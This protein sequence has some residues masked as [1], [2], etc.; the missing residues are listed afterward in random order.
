MT[1]IIDLS[2][3]ADHPLMNH[4]ELGPIIYVKLGSFRPVRRESQAAGD[5]S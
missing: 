1:Q 3:L 2:S 5:P 4:I